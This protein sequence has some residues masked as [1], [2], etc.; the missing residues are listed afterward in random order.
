MIFESKII[1]Q[2]I[3]NLTLKTDQVL[4]FAF[5]KMNA[6]IG[7][8]HH[9]PVCVKYEVGASYSGLALKSKCN[10]I[11]SLS[12]GIKTISSPKANSYIC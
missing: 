12:L 7:I 11:L 9:R 8:T 4:L 1:V 2:E 6:K 5:F 3:T 10:T